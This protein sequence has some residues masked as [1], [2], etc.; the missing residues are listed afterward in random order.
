MPKM[1]VACKGKTACQENN[2]Q[3]LTCGRSLDEIYSTRA[4]IDE[5]V[6]FAQKMGYQNSELFFEYIATKADKKIRHLQKQ[7]NTVNKNHEYH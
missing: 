1:F 3:C 2:N 5:L 7:D 6:L 4:L